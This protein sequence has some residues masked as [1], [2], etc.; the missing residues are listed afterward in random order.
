L[1]ISMDMRRRAA[2]ACIAVLGLAV[3]MSS[4][5]SGNK[6]QAKAQAAAMMGGPV[7]VTTGEAVQKTVPVEI[8]A[9]GNGEAYSTVTVKS[10]VDGIIQQADFTQGQFVKKGDVLFEIDQR[11]FQAALDQAR[12]NLAK[13]TAQAKNAQ[14]QAA[15]YAQLFKAG[16]VSQDQYDTYR[17][18]A[19]ALNASVQADQALLETA[20]LNLSYCTIRSPIDGRTGSL[21]VHPGNLIK[22]NDTSLVVIN[23]VSPLYVDFSVPEQYLDQVKKSMAH[24]RIPVQVAIPNQAQSSF[25]G[26]LSFVNNTVDSGTGTVMLKGTFGNSGHR[27]WPG[28][29]VNVSLILG[30]DTDVTAVPSEA[31]Q[32][33]QNGMYVY[34]VKP[35]MTVELRPVTV[36]ITYQGFTVIQKGLS[37]GEKVIREGQL[38][39][40]PGAKIVEKTGT[41]SGQN[42]QS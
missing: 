9:I 12:A 14:A 27:L 19:E 32:T 22:N 38:R 2:Q 11:P 21:L 34:A 10:Q 1:T 40:Y 25:D 7:P 20:R 18:N 17:T 33:G 31:V 41:A 36:G 8:H 4:A 24:G 13:D 37:P 23:Q 3:F 42:G 15:R 30:K 26:Y 28:Q 35:D 16:I 5:C 29:F 39:L 6:D